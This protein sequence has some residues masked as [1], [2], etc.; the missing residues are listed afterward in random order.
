[1][2]IKNYDNVFC[3]IA[4]FLIGGVTFLIIFFYS[5][6]FT[7]KSK[8][9]DVNFIEIIKLIIT[10]LIA[11]FV[12]QYVAIRNNNKSKQKEIIDRFLNKLFEFTLG[13]SEN[14]EKFMTDV[15]KSDKNL[16]SLT[17]K[18]F[19]TK[20]NHIKTN[21]QNDLVKTDIDH[22]ETAMNNIKNIVQT[23]TWGQDIIEYTQAN[24]SEVRRQFQNSQNYLMKSIFDNYQ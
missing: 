19:D 11:I 5:Y 7:I 18:S 14:I 24:I 21:I 23:E 20:L 8:F 3:S 10:L 22:I 16:I 4:A 2:K 9:W 6:D 15:N 1:M 12:A 13:M 17:F